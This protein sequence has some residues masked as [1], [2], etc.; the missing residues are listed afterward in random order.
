MLNLIHLPWRHAPGW[1]L[2]SA[3]HLVS[4]GSQPCRRDCSCETIC[5]RSATKC[6]S[7]FTPCGPPARRQ[8]PPIHLGLETT[9]LLHLGHHCILQTK[10]FLPENQLRSWWRSQFR[11]AWTWVSTFSRRRKWH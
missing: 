4:G 5:R 6:E 9:C 11:P 7:V 1:N 3:E 8:P 2:S 10:S